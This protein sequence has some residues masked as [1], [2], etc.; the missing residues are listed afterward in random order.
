MLINTKKV[1]LAL[2]LLLAPMAVHADDSEQALE[3]MEVNPDVGRPGRP[4]SSHKQLRMV[5]NTVV[6]P[7]GAGGH[8]ILRPTWFTT[9][10]VTHP[11]GTQTYV[12]ATTSGP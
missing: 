8:M 1:F 6:V 5:G 9:V 4:G 2:M 7:Y 10:P 3:A 11:F 12:L